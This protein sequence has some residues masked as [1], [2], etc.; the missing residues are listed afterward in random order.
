MSGGGGKS[1]ICVFFLKMLMM[2]IFFLLG[3]GFCFCFFCFLLL[4]LCFGSVFVF[5]GFVKRLCVVCVF[6]DNIFFFCLLIYC[7]CFILDG[8]GDCRFWGLVI[9]ILMVYDNGNDDDED[10]DD[11]FIT[12][13]DL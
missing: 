7:V 12:T 8:V 2:W 5:R 1:G 6:L 9:V 13:P 3:L 4:S 10:D 11:E